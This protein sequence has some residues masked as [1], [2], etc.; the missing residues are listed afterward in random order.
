MEKIVYRIVSFMVILGF[1]LVLLE[2]STWQQ[3]GV[4]P[5]T[6][7]FIFNPL[8]RCSM[9][10]DV[11]TADPIAFKYYIT[12]QIVKQQ[13]EISSISKSVTNINNE[14]STVN[15][16]V[17]NY[18]KTIEFQNKYIDQSN[19]NQAT[20]LQWVQENNANMDRLESQYNYLTSQIDNIKS[21]INELK[22]QLASLKKTVANK[23]NNSMI[24]DESDFATM[25]NDLEKEIKK[26][27]KDI[28]AMVKELNRN[29]SSQNKL[30]A[31]V[32]D[33]IN[34]I[35]KLNEKLDKKI[36]EGGKTNTDSAAEDKTHYFIIGTEDDLKSKKVI[37]T[38]GV[39]PNPN[40]DLFVPLTNK[41][42][43]IILGSGEFN[44]VVL[45]D[46]PTESYEIHPMSKRTLIVIWDI[47]AFWSKTEFLIVLQTE[48]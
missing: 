41:D 18:N 8:Q 22:D 44:Y 11:D 20:L 9:N 4:D 25:K 16:S 6:I 19:I 27:S 26:L 17:N 21:E 13:N 35:K 46:M 23:R 30:K 3:W 43:S 12:K 5:E 1:V 48:K 36:N 40:K 47:E 37:S 42:K 32:D 15:V 31:S 28:D 14:I 39:N 45:S 10:K 33:C 24:M 29:T 38:G 7:N 2:K 34:K